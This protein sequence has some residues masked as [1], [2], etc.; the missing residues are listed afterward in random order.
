MPAS[1]RSNAQ[2]VA[3]SI[4]YNTRDS[5]MVSYGKPFLWRSG[6]SQVTGD[7]VSLFIHNGELDYAHIR[8]NAY[9]SSKVDEEKHFNQMRVERYWLTFPTSRWTRSGPVAMLR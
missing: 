2:A 8:E 6:E 5:V 3:D 1:S 4:I 7:T 9:L